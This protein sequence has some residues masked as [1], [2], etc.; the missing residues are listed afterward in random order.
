MIHKQPFG[1]TGHDST[2]IIFGSYALSNATQ[3]EADRILELLLEY[4]VNHIDT[5]AMYGNAEKRIGP[6]MEKHRDDFFIGTKSRRRSY[7]GAWKDLQRSLN[8]LQVDSIDLWQMHGL[9]NPVSWEKVMGPGG[10]LE[11]FLE[12]RDEGMVR[13]LGVTG[14]GN[15]VPAM[16]K[17]KTHRQAHR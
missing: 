7:E 5:A 3:A 8:R 4:G 17:Q 12:A 9:T 2:R 10:A 14:H 11:A 13:F 15:K 6:W 1:R 16:H